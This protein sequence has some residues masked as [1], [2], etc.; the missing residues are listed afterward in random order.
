[1]EG[2]GIQAFD[3]IVLIILVGMTL[4]GGNKGMAWQIARL[5][6]ILVSW[7][8]ASRYS[9]TVAPMIDTEAPWNKILAMLILFAGTSLVIWIFFRFISKAIDRIQLREFD[10]QMGA[11]LGLIQGILL[12]MILAFFGVTLSERT[13]AAVLESISG[14]YLGMLV[15]QAE[16]T[17]P[18]EVAQVLQKHMQEFN[19]RLSDDAGEE[20]G[21]HSEE[22]G[23]ETDDAETSTSSGEQEGV[24]IE[25]TPLDKLKSGWDKLRDGIHLLGEG[26]DEIKE[27]TSG[28]SGSDSGAS[29]SSNIPPIPLSPSNIPEPNGAAKPY[30]GQGTF[31]PAKGQGGLLDGQKAWD[32]ETWHKSMQD[33]VKTPPPIPDSS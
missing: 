28:Y 2:I 4:Y 12:C 11:L 27:H 14:P 1:M 21:E 18:D 33:A 15:Q 23:R 25:P 7:E 13:R 17:M 32:V 16:A 30:S 6:S 31:T 22:E 29:N 10:R 3:I 26:R 20:S 5:G 8:V 24:A 9:P 19:H